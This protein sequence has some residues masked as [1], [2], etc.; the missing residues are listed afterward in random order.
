VI[1][2]AGKLKYENETDRHNCYTYSHD[3]AKP[4]LTFHIKAGLKVGLTKEEIIETIIL[5]FVYTGFPAALN[6]T[7]T[8]KEVY[9]NL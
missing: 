1:F 3:T 4:Q 2:I 7:S 5:M 9:A 6:G 8:A